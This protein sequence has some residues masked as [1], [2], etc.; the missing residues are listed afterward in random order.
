M[1]YFGN[2]RK[3]LNKMALQ[4]IITSL[5][6]ITIL[7]LFLF[8]FSVKYI[9]YVETKR[10]L[11][12]VSTLFENLY[13]NNTELISN[14]KFKDLIK[15]DEF[16]DITSALNRHNTNNVAKTE[17][18]IFNEDLN[19]IYSSYKDER[20]MELRLNYNKAILNNVKKDTNPFYKSVYKSSRSFPDYMI[21][22]TIKTENGESYVTS[23]ISGND[24]SYYMLSN[25][26]N[27]S[28]ITDYEN[29]VI[30]Y[31][32]PLLL[33]NNYYFDDVQS[34]AFSNKYTYVTKKNDVS[35]IKI[36]ALTEKKNS[37]NFIV[38]FIQSLFLGLI[39]Y[40]QS[41]K[42]TNII[43]DNNVSSVNALVSQ[44][45]SIK[46]GET[47][48]HI[49]LKTNDEYEYL[50]TEINQ[51]LNRINVLNEKNTELIEINNMIEMKQLL[52]QYNPHFLYNTLEII[53]SAYHVNPKTS[54]ELIVELS[55][56]L[57]YSI[58]NEVKFVTLE[59]DLR[60]I[61]SYLAIQKK[62]FHNRF[63]YNIDIT[64]NAKD[65][66]IPKLLLQ[67]ILENSIKYGFL[68]H[69]SVSIDIKG[70][71]K[72]NILTLVVTDDGP[73]MSDEEIEHIQN[74][75]IQENYNGKSIGL[76]NIARRLYL[77]D[78]DKNKIDITNYEPGGLKVKICINLDKE[79]EDV[80]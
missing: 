11:N 66:I 45:Q 49:I 55:K 42:M 50:A 28:V 80:S 32:K 35:Q 29:N 78:A 18:L 61:N 46:S 59:E 75:F 23:F 4:Q 56:I 25:Y 72:D 40:K 37:F 54:D 21:T 71:I 51:M 39:W 48:E 43:I 13:D 70:Y 77:L 68:S 27:D 62:R 1:E 10:N 16:D 34:L 22:K 38:Y 33:D 3:K 57:K 53:R 7:L 69:E 52:S 76:Y 47:D 58:N 12:E 79:Y 24:W 14:L 74:S 63:N 17:M 19:L 65:I 26:D 44:I 73:G 20:E 2:L 31:T 36:N 64:D 5:V 8:V 15:N 9:S 67:P 6:A 30:F 41:T 60:Y